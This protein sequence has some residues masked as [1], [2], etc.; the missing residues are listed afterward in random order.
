MDGQ[1]WRGLKWIAV[2]KFEKRWP[3]FLRIYGT[4]VYTCIKMSFIQLENQF[5]LLGGHDF[6]NERLWVCQFDI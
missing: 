4:P 1:N 5:Q 2:G 3:T 6:A